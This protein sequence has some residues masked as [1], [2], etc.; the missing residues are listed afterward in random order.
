MIA[1][2]NTENLIYLRTMGFRFRQSFGAGPFRINLSKSGVGWS[3][4][5]GGF[6]YGQSA[7]GRSYSTF[8][9]PGTGMSYYTSHGSRSRRG[10][11]GSGCM[12]PIVISGAL[13][14]IY[15]MLERV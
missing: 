4:G 11:S 9:V 14:G 5:G 12:I 13:I 6:R 2:A 3:V 10:G 15:L 8:S 7:R 1:V